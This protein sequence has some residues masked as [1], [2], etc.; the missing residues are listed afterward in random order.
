MKNLFSVLFALILLSIRPVEG[1]TSHDRNQPNV[2]VIIGDDHAAY[3]IGAYGNPLARTPNLDRLAGQ[4]A[5]FSQAYCNSPVCTPSRQSLLTGML[6][7]TVGV[8]QLPTA[9]SDDTQT[10]AEYLKESDYATA[11]I[12]KMHF[13]SPL[14]HGFDYRVDLEEH[15]Q[16]LS[17]QPRKPIPSGIEVLPAWKPFVD[18]ARIWLNGSCLPCGAYDAEMPGTWFAERAADYIRDHTSTPFLMFIGFTEPHS[19]FHFP[20]EFNGLFDPGSFIP[21]EIGPQ[22]DSQIPEIFRDLT[23]MEKRNITAAYFT[24]VAFLDKNVGRVLD[25]LREKGI[26]KN[27]IVV[28]LGDNGYNLGHHG[29]FEKH[30]FYEQAVRIPLLINDPSLVPGHRKI[31]AMVELIDLFP[32]ITDLCGL[33]APPQV[34][35]HSLVPLLKGDS[36]GGREFIFSEY[37]ENEEAMIRTRQF[38]YIYTTGAR[39]REDGYRTGR[40][41]PGRTRILFDIHQDPGEMTNLADNP[42]YQQ[43]IAEMKAEMLQCFEETYPLP[44]DKIASSTDVETRLDWYLKPRDKKNAPAPAGRK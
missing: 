5:I 38:K 27:T 2:V 31:D 6:P 34:Q 44:A 23:D 10:L 26:E 16:F 9:L 30:C 28:Y 19:P 32:T 4:G 37:L 41:L 43:V 21:P 36:E 7:H 42:E 39:N 17:S 35:G 40:P 22:D 12:G 24:S 1:R 20:I 29:R 25:A 11:A 13:N 3:A 18:P 15:R 8:T 33:P 14:H